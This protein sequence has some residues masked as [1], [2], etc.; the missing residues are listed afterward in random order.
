MRQAGARAQEGRGTTAGRADER[1][2]LVRCAAQLDVEH[3]R[4]LLTEGDLEVGA[5]GATHGS[6]GR[7]ER[8]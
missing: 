6:V 7:C 4:R 5:D 8:Q 2:H 1:E 3:D